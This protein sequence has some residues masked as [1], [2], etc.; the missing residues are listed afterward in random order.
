VEA[1]LWSLSKVNEKNLMN[2][3]SS[4]SEESSKRRSP[5]IGA[6]IFDGCSNKEK[7]VRDM[8]NLLTG[9]VQ[10]RIGEMVSNLFMIYF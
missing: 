6:V 9:R 4:S 8:T 1:F 7:I 10:E 3:Q 2:S 5:Q